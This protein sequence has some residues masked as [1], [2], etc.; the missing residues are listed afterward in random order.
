MITEFLIAN[1][2]FIIFAIIILIA[3]FLLCLF[4]NNIRETFKINTCFI[5]RSEKKQFETDIF[6]YDDDENKKL[7]PFKVINKLNTNQL[8][9]LREYYEKKEDCFETEHQSFTNKANMFFQMYI[10]SWGYI[11]AA[12]AYL[13]KE[14]LNGKYLL[15]HNSYI[16]FITFL[17]ITAHII[18]FVQ[19][20]CALTLDANY[21][22]DA[23][24]C[25]FKNILLPEKDFLK[26]TVQNKTYICN[27]NY[28]LLHNIKKTLLQIHTKFSVVL[29][30]ITLLFITI[31]INN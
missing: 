29:I 1:Y 2:N 5:T 20:I 27:C 28:T 19:V 23:K 9:E 21:E 15:I 10:F 31:F 22:T 6:G 18:F 13:Y 26:R 17:L 16:L 14:S 8:K 3:C 25:Y 30:L 7:P 24:N 4:N 11:G 12:A